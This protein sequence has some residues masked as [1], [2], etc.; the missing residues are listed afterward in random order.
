[1]YFKPSHILSNIEIFATIYSM[2]QSC[3][4]IQIRIVLILHLQMQNKSN[5]KWYSICLCMAEMSSILNEC[6][7]YICLNVC[8]VCQWRT[9]IDYSNNITI[10]N[11]VTLTDF[12]SK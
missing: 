3:R 10:H 6:N 4:F 9:N 5:N 12:A 11:Y 7:S 1:M 8:I 2:D